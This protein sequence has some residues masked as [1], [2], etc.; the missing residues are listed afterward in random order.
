MTFVRAALREPLLHFLLLAIV[1]YA[2]AAA[3]AR[4]TDPRRIEVTDAT[5]ASLAAR[6]ERQFGE[7]PSKDRL[8]LLIGDYV[9]DEALYRKG[10]ELGLGTGDE[11]VRRRVIQKMEFLADDDMAAGLSDDMLE[12]YFRAHADRY[13]EPGKVAFAQLYFS[14]DK[15]GERAA[16]DRAVAALDRLRN[17]TLANAIASDPAVGDAHIGLFDRSG[18]ERQ[19]GKGALTEGVFKAPVG[20]WAGPFRSGYGWHL[21]RVEERTAG[22]VPAFADVAEIVRGDWLDARRTLARKRARDDALRDFTVIR[23]DSGGSP[24][25]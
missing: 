19:F 11:V 6:Y 20:T 23:R 16:H 5:V 18:I 21:V 8:G 7:A 1:L 24:A 25:K 12:R 17:G 13:A 22:H 14:P 2:L 3:H 10:L 15:G 9:G 4:A